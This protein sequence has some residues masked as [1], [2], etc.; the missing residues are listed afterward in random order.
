MKAGKISFDDE[1]WT[2][3]SPKAKS[4]VMQLLQRDPTKRLTSAE[5]VTHPWATRTKTEPPPDCCFSHLLSTE[6]L[7]PRFG[8][9]TVD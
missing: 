1:E 5:L 6:S 2:R 4:L 8:R 3:V 9:A 7:H